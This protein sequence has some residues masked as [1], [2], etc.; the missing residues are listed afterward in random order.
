[1]S[2]SV[3]RP[4]C[5]TALHM[6]ELSKMYD[7]FVNNKDINNTILDA[8]EAFYNLVRSEFKRPLET[9]QFSKEL[10][11]GDL[12][13]FQNRLDRLVKSAKDGTFSNKFA[14]LMY[15]PEAFAKRDPKI[16]KLLDKYIQSSHYYTGQQSTGKVMQTD[17][18]GLL[19]REMKTRGLVS[20]SLSQTGKKI[21]RTSARAKLD[22]LE[23][24]IKRTIVDVKNGSKDAEIKL[25]QLLKDEAVL[26]RDSELSVY[27]EFV[28]YIEN[29]LPKLI[30]EKLK[31]N[32]DMKWTVK[33]KRAKAFFSEADFAKIKDANGNVIS[34]DMQKALSRYV[35][36]T[37]QLYFN[38]RDGVDRYIN[39]VMHGQTGKTADQIKNLRTRLEEK[40]M[41]DNKKGYYPHFTR[42]LSIDFMD[43]LMA[44]LDD[45]V[46]A[47]NKYMRK[48]LSLN[49]AIDNVNGYISG[50][51]KPQMSDVDNQSYSH[52]LPQVL[53][54][55]AENVNR[56]NYI[57]SINEATSNVLNSM[58]SMYKLGKDSSGY[59][60]EVVN[61][62]HDLHRSATG[63]DNIKNPALNN[64][65]RTILGFEFISKIGFNPRSAVRNVSQSMLNLV[66]FTPHQ[67][68]HYRKAYRD[69]S[70]KKELESIM[71]E[72]GL[73]FKD[74]APELQEVLGTNPS[75]ATSVKYNDVTKKYEFVEITKLAK[76]S[77][78]VSTLAGKAGFMMAGVENFNRKLTFGIAYSKM[79][80]ELSGADFAESMKTRL[81][82]IKSDKGDPAPTTKQIEAYVKSRRLAY[83]K[84]YATNMTVALH[85]DYNAFSKAKGLR[86]K[87]GQVVGQFQ[88][89]AFKF[90]ERNM[91]YLSK[92]KNDVLAGDLNGHNVWR[93]MRLGLAYFM[94]PMA[95]TA[96]TGVEFGNILEHDTSEKIKKLA[97]GLTGDEEAA[98]KAFYGKGP[99][100][101]SIGFPVYS[102]I[103][104]LG[105]MFD[106]INMDDDS[107][108]AY[109]AGLKDTNEKYNDDRLSQAIQ[110]LNP[111]IN[112]G[113][114][115]HL[116]QLQR[117]NIGWVIQSELG[118]YPTKEAKEKQ[119]KFQEA[120]SPELFALIEE[121]QK[122]GR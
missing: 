14:S 36:F 19:G 77:G 69:P 97:I 59:G 5:T 18:L 63:Y 62:V 56:F 80:D 34:N 48:N 10:S 33:K 87:T 121:L 21:T 85:F 88:H 66:Q 113:V 44:K 8:D 49:E 73:L 60:D 22:E 107:M 93:G 92:A 112:R 76:A 2:G 6:G 117:G 35:E 41:P 12:K 68:N 7:K 95:A 98:E 42:D 79:K 90:A 103:I 57:N 118:L 20:S 58:E 104:N 105:M 4:D 1:M 43:G 51:T 99:I 29:A 82:K 74:T 110:F 71:Q 70:A 28:G 39:T 116:P 50:H 119:K 101:G 32:P 106:L 102:D 38:L 83:A 26:F 45:M 52:N 24:D 23:M 89:Y 25:K 122:K 46:I 108:L 78:A 31:A 67:I 3:G 53:A 17:I 84:E 65:M 54:Q 47:S 91:E 109:I 120:T 114:Y 27:A 30:D 86:T 16:S 100:I 81:Q 55:Y 9:L 111:A 94:A 37:D 64:M 40:L 96:L 72:K 115:R 15:T 11:V 61:F 75:L 13:G